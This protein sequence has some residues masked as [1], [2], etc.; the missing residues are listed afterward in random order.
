M[1]CRLTN[2]NARPV[3]DASRPSS[4]SRTPLSRPASTAAGRSARSFRPLGSYLR[5]AVSTRPTVVAPRKLRPP[6]RRL[7]PRRRPQPSRVRHRPRRPLR[8]PQPLRQRRRTKSPRPRC[9]QS[10]RSDRQHFPGAIPRRHRRERRRAACAAA[11]TR[12]LSHE[13]VRPAGRRES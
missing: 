2:T 7:P 8:R 13:P 5:A 3:T 9:C 11:S 12:R 10:P 1:Q 4:A 6:R